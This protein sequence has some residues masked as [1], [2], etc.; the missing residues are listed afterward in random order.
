[1]T[2]VD[3]DVNPYSVTQNSGD[4]KQARRINDSLHIFI[5]KFSLRAGKQLK[6][7]QHQ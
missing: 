5:S 7:N 2:Y 3:V 6:V 4:C 1:M